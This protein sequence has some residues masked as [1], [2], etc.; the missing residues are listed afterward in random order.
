MISDL[1]AHSVAVERQRTL[2]ELHDVIGQELTMVVLECDRALADGT[3]GPGTAELRRIRQR[4][5]T[6]I[7]SVAALALGATPISLRDAVNRAA[8]DLMITGVAFRQHLDLDAARLEPE[9]DALLGCAVRE[10]VTNLLRHAPAASECVIGLSLGRRS[11]LTVRNDGVACAG[12]VRPGAGLR[13]LQERA[14]QAGGRI[15]IRAE[16]GSFTL[17]VCV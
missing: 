5:A 13:G 1:I 2:T 7:E 12:P 8:Q 9:T 16:R 14:A 6:L 10:G 3:D 11:V 4:A 15:G 17:T